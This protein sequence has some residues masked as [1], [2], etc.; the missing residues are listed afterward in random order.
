MKRKA[1]YESAWGESGR[2]YLF[3]W[4]FEEPGGIDVERVGINLQR[5]Q[6]P[7]AWDL[8]GTPPGS[9]F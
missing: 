8:V 7:V 4:P 2:A 3:Y 5:N 6:L 9:Y 1:V